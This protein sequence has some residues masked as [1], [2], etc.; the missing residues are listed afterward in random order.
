MERLTRKNDEGS[1]VT[2]AAQISAEGEE[3]GGPAIRRL[4]TFEEL[5]EELLAEQERIGER[6]EQLRQA[7]KKNSVQFKELLGKKL[8]NTNTI[9]LF[10]AYGL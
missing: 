7:D 8:M 10:K 3:W 1:Y 2:G 9:S 6:L 4:A 5:Y